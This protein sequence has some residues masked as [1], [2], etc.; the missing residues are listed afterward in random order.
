[1]EKQH[2]T[3]HPCGAFLFLYANISDKIGS[4]VVHYTL[5]FCVD[6]ADMIFESRV[7]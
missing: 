1:M 5:Q 6:N 3:L 2:T 4:N 7:L